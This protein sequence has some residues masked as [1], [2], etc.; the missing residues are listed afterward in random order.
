MRNTDHSIGADRQGL[1]AEHTKNSEVA[2]QTWVETPARISCKPGETWEYCSPMSATV[3]PVGVPH[4][5][6][7]F[8]HET[9]KDVR[10]LHKHPY[11]L[12]HQRSSW[13]VVARFIGRVNLQLRGG[14]RVISPKRKNIEVGTLSPSQVK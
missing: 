10:M 9:A 14:E 11:V 13:T 12:L 1:L 7:Q 4:N 5:L 2:C 8:F 6:R 3:S